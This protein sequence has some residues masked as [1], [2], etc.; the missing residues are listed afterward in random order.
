MGAQQLLD[1]QLQFLL[2]VLE[3]AQENLCCITRALQQMNATGGTFP[4]T[5]IGLRIN[6]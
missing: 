2:T 1:Q 4:E 5:I 6:K 3:S